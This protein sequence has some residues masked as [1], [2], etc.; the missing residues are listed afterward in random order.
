MEFVVWLLWQHYRGDGLGD[1]GED[2][3][4]QRV[5]ED[6]V[7]QERDEKQVHTVIRTEVLQQ[8]RER[9]STAKTQNKTLHY[10]FNKG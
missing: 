4:A 6:L 10:T 1:A 9:G 3:R 2:G 7:F 5:D 8:R